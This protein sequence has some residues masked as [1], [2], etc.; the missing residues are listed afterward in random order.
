MCHAVRLRA[1]EIE[2]SCSSSR[3]MQPGTSAAGSGRTEK[4][5]RSSRLAGLWRTINV[6][7]LYDTVVAP[8][9][10]CVHACQQQQR[11]GSAATAAPGLVACARA[12]WQQQRAAP[13]AGR[14]STVRMP[15]CPCALPQVLC[16]SG[17]TPCS[18]RCGRLCSGGRARTDRVRSCMCQQQAIAGPAKC[19]VLCH[20][21]V[22]HV[23]A[24]M[25]SQQCQ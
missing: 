2:D 21:L 18:A 13:H 8:M 23:S 22:S 24:R 10:V 15:R 3:G 20:Y 11:A 6:V 16:T 14:C 7:Q 19:N 17:C 12:W 1:C 5:A 4:A 25:H 9:K